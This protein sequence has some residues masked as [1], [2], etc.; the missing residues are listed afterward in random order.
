MPSIKRNQRKTIQRKIVTTHVTG[1]LISYKDGSPVAEELPPVT[2]VGRLNDKEAL[3]AL[4][5]EYGRDST[6][7]VGKIEV[8]EDMYEMAI[9]DFLQ[10][11]TKT[12]I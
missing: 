9:T 5:R 11:A 12:T 10:Y 1:L 3:T 8:H 6:I 7:T 2:V 4:Y